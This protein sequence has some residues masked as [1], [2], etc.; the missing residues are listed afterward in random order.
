MTEVKHYKCD[1]CGTEYKDKKQ[2][3]ECEKNHV[4]T[5]EIVSC[6]FVRKEFMNDG[7]PTS[8]TVKSEDGRE[9]RYDIWED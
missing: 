9:R 6:K 1:I 7:F 3:E 4:E 5:I 8:I 2:A